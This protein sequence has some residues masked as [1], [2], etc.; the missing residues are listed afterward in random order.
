M[1]NLLRIW[2]I[3]V[4]LA[5]NSAIGAPLGLPT[6]VCT[7]TFCGLVQQKMWQRFEKAVG[8]DLD[9]IPSVYSGNCY[10]NSPMLDP[11]I[12]HFGGVL[13]DKRGSQVFFD[14]KFSFFER[15]QPYAHLTLETAR[16]RFAA[17]WGLTLH[18]EFAY[19]EASD[20]RQPFRY[21]LRQDAQGDGLLLVGYFGYRHTILCA[22]DRHLN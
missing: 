10:H 14:G 2:T 13:I 20:S 12:N 9:L 19:A 15:K 7:G 8:L 5:H 11:H 4:L 16:I 21:W 6:N 18:D 1:K 22:L 3:G 17:L